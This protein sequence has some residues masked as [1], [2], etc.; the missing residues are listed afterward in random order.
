MSTPKTLIRILSKL[1]PNDVDGLSKVLID[2]VEG[3]ASVGFMLP[4]TMEKAQAFWKG[5]A[6]SAARGERLILVAEDELGCVGSVQ[7]IL[8]QP[9]NQPH[10]A[11]LA[12]MLVHRRGR[13]SGIGA[14]LLQEGE[15]AAISAGKKL[16]VL[17]TAN[18]EAERLYERA[19][20]KSCGLIPNYALMPDGAL[21]STRL[22]Y[23]QLVKLTTSL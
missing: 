1:G 20:W 8:N 22:Y 6:A 19:G 21:C 3:G 13:R 18:P 11:D 4:M 5:A 14:A 16:L 23:K 15:R 17:D 12:K 10:R 2:C 9:E 7:I